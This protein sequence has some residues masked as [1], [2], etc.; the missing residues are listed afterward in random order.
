MSAA[1]RWD[2]RAENDCLFV[3]V[4][5]TQFHLQPK[6]LQTAGNFPIFRLIAIQIYSIMKLN[7]RSLLVVVVR[8][9]LLGRSDQMIDRDP[10]QTISRQTPI[11]MAIPKS[12]ESQFRRC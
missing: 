9:F 8:L 5:S 1:S 12:Y 10:I 3:I 4:L 11:I 7:H 6:P 2:L